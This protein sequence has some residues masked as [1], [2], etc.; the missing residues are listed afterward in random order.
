MA[1]FSQYS[2]EKGSDTV[3][4]FLCSTCKDEE[5]E[6]GADY[7]CG[8][9]VKFYCKKCI[10]LHS[11]LFKKHSPHGRGDM[12]KW[13]VAKE[14]EDFLLRCDVH[15]EEHLKMF[16][17]GH[18]QLCCC[19]CSFLN[20]RQ[21]KEV[22]LL[23]DMVK[24]TSTDLKQQSVTIETTLAEL[25]NIQDNQEASI[26][27]VQSSYDEQLHK[28]QETRREINAALERLEKETLKEMKHTL[29]KLQ[30]SLTSDVDKYTTL[31]EELKQLRDAM[32]NIGGK[33]KQELSFIASIKCQD[34]IQQYETLQK[35]NLE[36]VNSSITFQPNG[37]IVQ[38]LSNLT[39]LG[40]IEHN[41]LTVQRKPDPIIKLK[42]KIIKYDVRIL[43][44]E[45]KCNISAIC[46]LPDRQVLVV[47]STNN[48]VK[49]LNRKYRVVNHWDEAAD[50]MCQIAPSEVAVTMNKM[51][52]FI[53]VIN[54]QLV[55][56]RELQ[57]D[58]KCLGIAHHQGDLFVTSGFALYKYTLSG[59]L[60]SQLYM[61][62]S[63]TMTFNTVERCAVSLTGDK[64]YISNTD[65]HTVLTLA[66]D[67]TVLSVFKVPEL[68]T[69]YGIHVTPAGQ[70]LVCAC[71]G[72]SAS[73]IIQMDSKGGKELATLATRR[74]WVEGADSVCY[75]SNTASIIVGQFENNSILVFKV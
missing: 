57:L 52:K 16:C 54:N 30:V 49:L 47:D 8:S 36:Q 35:K 17:K 72:Y 70:V 75:N 59:Q 71:G 40:R 26:Q 5:L 23:S 58:H 2:V 19:N 60:V 9:C 14:A 12:K 33:S 66:R 28:I 44:D 61:D 69:P 21:C 39:G 24:K 67:G 46:V 63:D 74:D 22:L 45:Q 10:H 56:G 15:K 20:H 48:K 38:Y 64:L 11:Q 31:R 51:V 7:Y 13:P 50:D 42:G 6:E 41:T 1:T 32:H 68:L 27:S 3:Q 62:K 55:K 73:S 29:T 37:E 4:D 18:S 65:Q 43:S 53:T 25:K 34:K